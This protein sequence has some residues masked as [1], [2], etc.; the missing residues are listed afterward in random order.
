MSELFLWQMI[1]NV[2]KILGWLFGY[3]L[4]AK[5]MVKYTVLTE[6][7]FAISWVSL[8]VYF[9]NVYGLIGVTYAYVVNNVLHFLTMFYIYKFELKGKNNV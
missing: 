6:I 2:I 7:I 9:I 8:S 4:V 5:A 3:I 1:G